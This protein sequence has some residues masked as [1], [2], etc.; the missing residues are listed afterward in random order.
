MRP[1]ARKTPTSDAG[2]QPIS[3]V[4]VKDHRFMR[5]L[6]SSMLARQEGQYKLVAEDSEAATAI[7]AFEEFAPDLLILDIDLPE[8]SGVDA[9]AQIREHAPKFRIL[10][11]TAFPTDDPVVEPLRSGVDRV[12][13]KTN[14]WEGFIEAFERVSR[15]M[16]LFRSQSDPTYQIPALPLSP[17]EEEI[18]TLIA[19]NGS[20]SEIA[21]KL[22]QQRSGRCESWE[23]TR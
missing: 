20:D 7:E 11:C 6:I 5:E 2:T 3:V 22:Y 4:V 16:H 23:G 17:R 14:T 13:E 12:V 9:V 8:P 21:L 18:L 15:G 10:L 19:G 1:N